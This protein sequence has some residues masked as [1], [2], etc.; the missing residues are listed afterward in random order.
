MKTKTAQPLLCSRS[1]G[2]SLTQQQQVLVIRTS[3]L[4]G[5]LQRQHPQTLAGFQLDPCSWWES[6]EHTA[7]ALQFLARFNYSLPPGIVQHEQCE[8]EPSMS[9]WTRET[10]FPGDL[11]FMA[12]TA[13]SSGKTFPQLEHLKSALCHVVSGGCKGWAHSSASPLSGHGGFL[14]FIHPCILTHRNLII[15]PFARRGIYTRLRASPKGVN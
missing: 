10:W 11:C 1:L 4:S 13:S 9:T 7:L 15:K 12:L 8:V 3:V 2:S 5:F 14:S 6:P